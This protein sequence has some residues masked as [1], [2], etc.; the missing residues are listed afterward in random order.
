M[1]TSIKGRSVIVTGGSKGIGKGI[2]QV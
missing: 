1:L 2:A